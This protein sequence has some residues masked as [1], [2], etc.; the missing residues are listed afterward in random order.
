MGLEIASAKLQDIIEGADRDRRMLD[1][2][3]LNIESKVIGK[4]TTAY[5]YRGKY[6][7][8]RVAIKVFN[9]SEI[10]E[11]YVDELGKEL[12]LVATLRH[13]NVLALYGLCVRPPQL[14]AVFELCD[15][16]SLA[17][18]L[19]DLKFYDLSLGGFIDRR[20]VWAFDAASAVAY[21]HTNAI[22]HRDIKIDN[23]LVATGTT[24]TV[25]LCDFGVSLRRSTALSRGEI[26]ATHGLMNNA[27]IEAIPKTP[28]RRYASDMY[29]C[30]T[31]KIAASRI[32]ETFIA[33]LRRRRS[34]APAR[35]TSNSC[36]RH[37]SLSP[38]PLSSG[39]A[40]TP[41][42]SSNTNLSESSVDNQ[43]LETN[44][45]PVQRVITPPYSGGDNSTRSSSSS[46]TNKLRT[47]RYFHE[48]LD[49]GQPL[50]IV[51]TVAY[52]APELIEARRDY[53]EA[54]DIYALGVVLRC[55]W[56]RDPEPWPRE[57]QTFEIYDKVTNGQR[58]RLP[59]DIPL[60][61]STIINQAWHQDPAQ[62]PDAET[63][64]RDMLA[65]ISQHCGGQTA[66]S[67]LKQ[68]VT[69]SNADGSRLLHRK[70][71]VDKLLFASLWRSDE[72]QL[73]QDLE[74]LE[75]PSRSEVL[76]G[77][78]HSGGTSLSALSRNRSPPNNVSFSSEVIH[79]STTSHQA[80]EKKEDN[81]EFFRHSDSEE[82][83]ENNQRST[84]I[85]STSTNDTR[86][87]DLALSF[88]SSVTNT[89]AIHCENNDYR[90]TTLSAFEGMT[91]MPEKDEE[92]E[93]C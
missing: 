38:P 84:S 53:N 66:I 39:S 11:E 37:D 29:N 67:R 22:W 69:D 73:D 18:A 87:S 75:D 14:F 16:G 56:C 5:V 49:D 60:V 17:S 26:W 55:L 21:L 57:A 8:D 46:P 25:K 27:T 83:I 9:P 77:G 92:E 86:P 64:R 80:D 90:D 91:T 70:S 72:N 48:P 6:R 45:R 44:N 85:L 3:H 4:G 12:H 62:R 33:P 79:S 51:G 36:E 10:T 58:P 31:S 32:S 42:F 68:H 40:V 2:E 74:D 20:L 23:F 15:G 41:T 78:P 52:M 63:L 81:V 1:F 59:D 24:A 43:P 34:T 19:A 54:V 13:R 88:Q 76:F 35:T 50:V 61:L 7:E 47:P 65:A 71:F 93:I 30:T 89:A 28:V 82:P